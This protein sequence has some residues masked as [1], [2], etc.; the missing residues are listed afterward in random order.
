MLSLET[1]GGGGGG[2]GG[3]H[4][5]LVLASWECT[6]LQALHRLR[7]RER[8]C[9]VWGVGIWRHVYPYKTYGH[10]CIWDAF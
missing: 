4:G 7:S 8:C 1:K 6:L 10:A 9:V 3:E 5:G 2:E